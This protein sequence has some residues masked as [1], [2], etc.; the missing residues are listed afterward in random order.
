M[1]WTVL[2]CDALILNFSIEIFPP[3]ALTI[4][5]NLESLISRRWDSIISNANVL[6]TRDETF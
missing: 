4:N 3:L 1:L 2:W 6:Q 5:I